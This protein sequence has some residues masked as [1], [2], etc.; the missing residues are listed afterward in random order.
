M[1][2]ETYNYHVG[3]FDI[4]MMFRDAWVCIFTDSFVWSSAYLNWYKV[5]FIIV[6]HMSICT[7]TAETPASCL[8]YRLKSQ[9]SPFFLKQ[10]TST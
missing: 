5:G 1:H 9:F 10:S 8:L 6:L 7:D 4:K 3:T 2:T